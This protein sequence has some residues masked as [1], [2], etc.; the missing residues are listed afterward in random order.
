MS[1]SHATTLH[2]TVGL[3]RRRGELEG[4]DH[5][6]VVSQADLSQTTDL[7]GKGHELS[8]LRTVTAS[9]G[10][11]TTIDVD[12]SSTCT[13]IVAA[14]SRTAPQILLYECTHTANG[15]QCTCRTRFPQHQGR[16]KAHV[17]HLQASW[18]ASAAAAYQIFLHQRLPC[19]PYR[20]STI[21][22]DSFITTA[23]AQGGF[24]AATQHIADYMPHHLR[25]AVK[26]AGRKA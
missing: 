23:T 9:S 6:R 12:A 20:A 5:L 22:H 8:S 18:V 13:V 24:P 15:K 26:N 2:H 10:P 4:P 1:S 7:S 19:M 16:D 21:E 14:G 3:R 17:Q 25:K 11:V